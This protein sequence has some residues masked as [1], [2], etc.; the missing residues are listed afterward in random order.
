MDAKKIT[1]L[2]IEPGGV[3]QKILETL[4]VYALAEEPLA[5][6]Q[7]IELKEAVWII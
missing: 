6:L 4:D 2:L 3:V 5:T 1:E 7:S